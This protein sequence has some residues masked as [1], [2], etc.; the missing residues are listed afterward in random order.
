MLYRNFVNAFCMQIKGVNF[1]VFAKA[2]IFVERL[3]AIHG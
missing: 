3:S 1:K 2:P